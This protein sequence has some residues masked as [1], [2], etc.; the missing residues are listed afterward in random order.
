MTQMRLYQHD[1]IGSIV[2]YQ[3]DPAE[4]EQAIR[5]FLDTPLRVRMLVVDN[6]PTDAL[7]PYVPSTGNGISIYREELWVWRW[8]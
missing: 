7:G 3:S 5:S 8:T 2:A 6:S 1:V 4:L